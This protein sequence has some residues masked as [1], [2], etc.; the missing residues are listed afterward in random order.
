MIFTDLHTHTCFCDG[1]NTPEEMI[2]SAIEK[3]LKT[4][5]LV[6]HAYIPDATYCVSLSGAEEFK[7]QV[8]QLKEKYKDKITVL[9]GVETD[10]FSDMS[11]SGFDY[12]IGSVHY[13]SV[14][15]VLFDVD[16]SKDMFVKIVN[17]VF[18]GD[19]YAA[20]ENY[21]SSVGKVIEKTNADIIGH[22]DLITKF[23]Q[24]DCLFSTSHPRYIAAVNG[25]LDKLVKENKP[26]EINTGAM[27]RGLRK[28]P[29][30]S[31]DIIENIKNRGGKF[32]LSS[33]SHSAQNIAY[34]FDIW[35]K[36]L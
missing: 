21:Y 24:D 29:Y 6:V 32:V 27:A 3:G 5:G 28:E 9:C 11:L 17:E 12:I 22:F 31:M 33:D 19:Y 18:G 8:N 30:P 20:A 34:Q 4:I 13:F 35:Q 7:K 26:F 2:L 10:Y 16:H 1:K 15:G 25:A 23:N 36:L 14:D